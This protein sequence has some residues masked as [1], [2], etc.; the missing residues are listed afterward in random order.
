MILIANH[1]WQSTL[2][3]VAVLLLALAF[4][5]RRAQPRY[6]IWL[7]ASLKFLIP[8]SLLV[9]A[10]S[11]LE[12][13]TAPAVAPAVSATV[14]QIS[15]AFTP[16]ALPEAA[17]AA[18]GRPALARLLMIVWFCGC[19]GVLAIWCLRWRRVRVALRLALPCNI[20]APIPVMAS[21]SLLEPGVFGVFRPVLLL[22]A[23]IAE[24]LTAEQLDAILA[25][26]L[27]HVRRRD[28][29]AAAMHMLVEAIFWFH[30]LVWWIGARLIEERERACDEEVLRQ[31][32]R[33]QVY[34]EGILTVCRLYLE[35]PLPCASGVTGSELRKRIEAIMTNRIAR[36]LTPAGKLVLA[37]AGMTAVA[38]PILIGIMRA[39]QSRAQTNTE[40]VT[41][42]VASIRPSRPGSR[43][44]ILQFT[45]GGG[46]RTVNA[47]LRQLI[48]VAYDVRNFQ[49]SGGPAWLNTQGFDI[50]AK[51]SQSAE[52]AAAGNREMTEDRVPYVRQRIQA[53]L[54]ERFQLSIRR[55]T[56]QMPAYALVVAKNG[57]KLKES[58]TGEGRGI[59]ADRN[60][61]TGDAARISLLADILAR[62]TG[63]PVLDR[64]G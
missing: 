57:P 50:L 44:L 6:W 23:G 48:E 54:A 14:E 19:A 34:A 61:V 31:G 39:P 29:L 45:P 36:G 1:L 26:E 53:L 4:R 60:L 12:W 17:P 2:F 52:S 55:G 21:A 64:T 8:F 33:P 35:S 3:A 30:P 40:A 56:R 58:T 37:I 38:A 16:L 5:S 32:K 47:H 11:Q 28:N 43:G 41:F 46:L 27:C 22:P 18:T 63:R 25:H 13:R 9:S 62:R 7:A 24:R 10:G 42:E 49:I 59:N 15:E 20:E 51:A